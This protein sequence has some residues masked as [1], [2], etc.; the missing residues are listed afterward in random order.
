MS[1][2]SSRQFLS[3]T[4]VLLGLHIQS[5]IHEYGMVA[6]NGSKGLVILITTTLDKENRNLPAILCMVLAELWQ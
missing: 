4:V 1:I 2:Q 5:I 6:A 3:K